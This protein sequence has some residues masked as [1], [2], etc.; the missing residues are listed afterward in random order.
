MWAG[1]IFFLF[2]YPGSNYWFE[3]CEKRLLA[4]LSVLILA[5]LILGIILDLPTLICKTYDSRPPLSDFMVIQRQWSFGSYLFRGGVGSFTRILV[6]RVATTLGPNL[7]SYLKSLSL[8]PLVFYPG[9]KI[10]QV[11]EAGAMCLPSPI[12]DYCILPGN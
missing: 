4:Y 1:D 6:I 3:L 9:T 2:K 10:T 7:Y 5:I 8:S 11:L 12:V